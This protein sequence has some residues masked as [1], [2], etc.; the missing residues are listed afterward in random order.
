M[1]EDHRSNGLW[2][3]AFNVDSQSGTGRFVALVLAFVVIGGALSW[4]VG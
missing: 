2:E 3:K 1:T 4:F